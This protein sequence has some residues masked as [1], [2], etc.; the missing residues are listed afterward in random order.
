MLV[1]LAR[2][3][4]VL[5]LAGGTSQAERPNRDG[6]YPLELTQG[7]RL[8]VK[9]R[10][11]GETVD[12][13]LDSAAEATLLDTQFARRLG[14]LGDQEVT[15]RGSG[16]TKVQASLAE[17]VTLEAF[18]LTLRDQTVGVLD[19]GDV[20][21]R[22]LNRPLEVV[23][24]REVFDHARLEIDIEGKTLRVVDPAVEP[25]GVRLPLE[26][27]HGIETIPVTIEGQT[28]QAE[29][30]VANGSG[31]MV[32]GGFAARLLADGRSVGSERGGGIGGEMQRQTLTLSVLELAGRRFDNVPASVDPNDN[33]HD[34]NVGVS[35]LRHFLITTDY[36]ARAV[37]L[38]PRASAEASPPKR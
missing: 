29:L 19:L 6:L 24:G 30:D 37:W 14:L 20:G 36:K 21:R 5:L 18:G 1:S 7:S 26:S 28:V 12:A 8:M 3:L 9:A 23:L 34:A 17:G 27:G 31:V 35:V 38:S 4:A 13:L 15:A 2:A 32:G 16:E 25:A 33:A 22:L 11:N 10:V